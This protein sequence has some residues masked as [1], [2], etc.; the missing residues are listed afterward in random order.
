MYSDSLD[1]LNTFYLCSVGV[2]CL[3]QLL[4][5]VMDCL[6]MFEYELNSCHWYLSHFYPVAIVCTTISNCVLSMYAANIAYKWRTMILVVMR[7]CSTII[8]GAFGN[9]CFLDAAKHLKAEKKR[10]EVDFAAARGQV[11]F[12]NIGPP[13]AI[14]HEDNQVLIQP[15]NQAVNEA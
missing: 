12:I 8:F 6:I 9:A 5:S 3:L 13:A 11:Y 7:I 14:K 1:A 4:T 10:R 2:E 15:D